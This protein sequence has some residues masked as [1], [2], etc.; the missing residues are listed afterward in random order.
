M[1][2]EFENSRP[3]PQKMALVIFLA[4]F[5]QALSVEQIEVPPLAFRLALVIL[6][7]GGGQEKYW[8]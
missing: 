2:D 5:S 4:P 8:A 3:P 7:I 1:L 6:R